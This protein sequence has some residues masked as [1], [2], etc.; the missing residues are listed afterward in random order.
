MRLL[1]LLLALAL[2]LTARGQTYDPATRVLTLPTLT[3]AG[4]RYSEVQARLDAFTVLAVGGPAIAEASFDAAT[5]TLA[6]PQ[7]TVGGTRHLN[8]TLRLESV[9]VLAAIPLATTAAPTRIYVNLVS[10]NEDTATGS[11]ADCLAFFSDAERLYAANSAALEAIAETVRQKGASYNFQTDV[12][13]LNLVLARESASN[14]VLRRLAASHAGVVEIDAHAHESQRKNYADVANLVERVAGVRN[15]IV[16]GFTAVSCRPNQPAPDWEKF[17]APLAPASGS[18]SSF[19]AR[20]L[21]LGSSGGHVCDPDASGIWR[22]AATDDFFTDDPA[23]S[24]ITIGTGY[25]AQGLDAA[26]TAIGRLVEDLRAGR[27]AQNRMYT[28]SVTISHCN[29]HLADRGATPADVARFIDAVNALDG[30]S[31]VIRWATF[32][33]MAEIWR[34]EYA[35]APSVWRGR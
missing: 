20:I 34:T 26:V 5:R 10:H 12:E 9:S 13:Y 15:G 18:G 17:R 29:M 33:R 3:V 4:A 23:Q 35:S 31:G 22:P 1:F 24:L 28:A 8:V 14:N 30:G 2:S 7:V 27:L 19:Q 6:L 32:S 11:N 21:T 25:A 16:G